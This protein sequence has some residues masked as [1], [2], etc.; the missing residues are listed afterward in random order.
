MNSSLSDGDDNGCEEAEPDEIISIHSQE[1]SIKRKETEG[2]L[3]VVVRPALLIDLPN[4]EQDK[5]L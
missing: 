1:S 3:R 2:R 5:V 4:E